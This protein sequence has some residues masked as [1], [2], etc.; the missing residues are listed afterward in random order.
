MK[1][2]SVTKLIG[3]LDKPALMYW[4]NKQGLAGIDI[5]KERA[6]TKSEG[7]SLHKQIETRQFDDPRHAHYCDNFMR[8]KEV[9]RSEGK[10]ETEWF[11]G[12]YD[13]RMKWRSAEFI[14][15]WKSSGKLYFESKLQLAAYGMAEPANGY[16]I[17][18]VPDFH[19]IDA[20]IDRDIGRYWDILIALS[21]IYALRWEIENDE[22]LA[23]EALHNEAPC[24]LEIAS[25]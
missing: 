5:K 18:S 21:K 22:L 13:C 15:D 7:N 11:V 24:Q 10:I 8:D 2:P 4:A 20:K 16:G 1:K 19:F 3:M 17:V 14:F 9:V 12:R 25:A 23:R 6:R